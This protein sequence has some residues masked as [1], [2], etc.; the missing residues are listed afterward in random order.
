MNRAM[1][2]GVA[3]LK[4]HQTKMDVIGNNIANVN[5]Y[6]YKSQ[7][8][9]FSDI[10]YQTVRSASE[11]TT[12]RGGVNPSSVGYGSSLAAIQTQMTQSS[13]QNTGFGMDVA[14]MGEGFLQVMD[15]NGNTFYTKAGMLDYDS[16]GYLTDI[17]GNFV[18]GTSGANSEPG[19]QKIKLDNIGSV[20]AKKPMA[21]ETINGIEYTVTASNPGQFGNVSI[22]I[23][24]SENL[25]AGLLA[26]ASISNAGA[27]TVQLN[28]FEEFNSMSEVNAAINAA[29]T[30][31]NGGTVHPGGQFTITAS[32]NVFGTDPSVGTWTGAALAEEVKLTASDADGLFDGALS[33]TGSDLYAFPATATDENMSITKQ[34]TGTAPSQVIEYVV[35]MQVAGTTYEG[36]FQGNIAADATI[37]LSDVT[38]SGS[39]KSITLSVSDKD[40]LTNTLSTLVNNGDNTTSIVTQTPPQYFFGGSTITSVTSNFSGQGDME[41][42]YTLNT[43]TNMYEVTATIGG[44]TYT[45][46][47]SSVNGGNFTLKTAGDEALDGSITMSVPSRTQMLDHYGI[48]SADPDADTKLQTALN[49]SLDLHNYVAIS[50]TA[51][52]SKA[53][54]GAEISGVNFGNYPGSIKGMEEGAFGG[55]MFLMKTSSNFEG[56]GTV[57]TNDFKATYTHSDTDPDFWTISMTID[58]VEYKA[59]IAE[60]TKAS[61]LLLKGPKGDYVQVSN[62]GYDAMNNYYKT[63]NPATDPTNGDEMLALTGGKELT[64]TASEPSRNLGLSAVTFPL[65]GGTEGGTVTLDELSSIAIASDGTISVSHADKGTVVAGK[66]SLANFANASGLQL[67]GSNYFSATANSGEPK[68]CDPGSEGSGSLKSSALEMSNVDLSAEFAEMITTQRGFQA[69][70]RIITVSDTML[71][72][73]IN[74][75]R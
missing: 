6:A 10:Y 44:K 54:T 45:G 2:S 47:V 46:E 58:G 27:I 31:A 7:R 17:N 11:G 13:L 73:L 40:Q 1:F 36:K 65:T 22:A 5:T 38:N 49:D 23:G 66:I 9:I 16:N 51:G 15:P 8:A 33:I 59:D 19:A 53:L 32:E 20:D 42:S 41:Y 35:S 71:E 63:L 43:T 3:G 24:S 28:A 29:I 68:L 60:D 21:D 12:S 30:E 26:S 37:E 56:A 48:D 18:L 69:N 64:V 67:E 62:P 14:I 75:K 34:I 61:S 52:E 25:P 72:E 55:T 4:T 70:S 74:L 50:A 39:T 57:T